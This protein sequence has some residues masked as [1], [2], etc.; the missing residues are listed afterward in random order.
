[1]AF[2]L[3]LDSMRTVIYRVLHFKWPNRDIHILS[4]IL[5]FTYPPPTHKVLN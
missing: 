3:T 4:L 1:M 2:S 5:S